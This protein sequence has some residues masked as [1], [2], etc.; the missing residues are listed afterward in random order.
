MEIA[1]KW[2][3]KQVEINLQSGISILL[4]LAPGDTVEG[5]YYLEKGNKVGFQISG[6]SLMYESKPDVISGNVTS[7]RFSFTASADQ[8]IA[9]TL[10][11]IPGKEKDEKK[12]D[13]TVFLEIIYPVT[14]E[15]FDPMGT[16]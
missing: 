8:G 4:K 5:Y 6:N 1:G 11:F 15:V 10:K 7:D 13:T 3:V 16:K 14:G 12:V 2:A 9:Y